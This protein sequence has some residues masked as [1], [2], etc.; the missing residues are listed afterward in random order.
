MFTF[1]WNWEKERW[2]GLSFFM[3][4]SRMR[5]FKKSFILINMLNK[6]KLKC[7]GRSRKHSFYHVRS[8]TVSNSV[9]LLPMTKIKRPYSK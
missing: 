2:D 3:A 9:S 7:T 8:G 1:L 6:L 5:L 4:W